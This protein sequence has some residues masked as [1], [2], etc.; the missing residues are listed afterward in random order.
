MLLR[1]I[2]KVKERCRGRIRRLYYTNCNSNISNM[3][4]AI[5]L[6]MGE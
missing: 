1:S 3:D 2:L 4:N 6:F 5:T